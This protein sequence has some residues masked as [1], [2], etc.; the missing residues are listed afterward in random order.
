MT[1]S[2]LSEL[3]GEPISDGMPHVARW[4]Q[5]MRARPCWAA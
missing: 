3:L 5:Q 1:A 4:D 2:Q